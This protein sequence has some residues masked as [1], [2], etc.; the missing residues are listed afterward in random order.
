MAKIEDWI[1]KVVQEIENDL[2]QPNVKPGYFREVI[3]THCPFQQGALYE[4][5]GEDSKKLDQILK[6]LADM[7]A[8]IN[9][10][11]RAI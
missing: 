3:E 10:I 7:R 11:R 2:D 5:V 8:Q 9:T 6:E 1:E 4:E